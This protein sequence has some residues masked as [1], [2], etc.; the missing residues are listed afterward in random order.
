M[1]LWQHLNQHID[2]YLQRECHKTIFICCFIVT[3]ENLI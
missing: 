1:K 2:I 3:A